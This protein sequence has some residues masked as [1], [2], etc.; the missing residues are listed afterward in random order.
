MH[1]LTAGSISAPECPPARF[2]I[3][4]IAQYGT[5]KKWNDTQCC[6]HLCSGCASGLARYCCKTCKS[7]D[8]AT[9]EKICCQIGQS[10]A[11]G[12]AMMAQSGLLLQILQTM[13]VLAVANA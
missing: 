7:K 5:A 13:R 3:K 6:T 1:Q 9:Q 12:M 4:L 2:S 10:N 8:W 11:V